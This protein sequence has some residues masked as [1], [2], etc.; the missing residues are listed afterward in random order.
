MF[1]FDSPESP[2]G[3]YVNMSTFQAR[4]LRALRACMV[5]RQGAP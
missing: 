2:G 4:A 3:L 5:T 1:S